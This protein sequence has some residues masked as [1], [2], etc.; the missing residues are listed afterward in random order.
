MKTNHNHQRKENQEMQSKVYV[1]IGQRWLNNE[2]TAYMPMAEAL[3]ALN[4]TLSELYSDIQIDCT[5]D[6]TCERSSYDI[7]AYKAFFKLVIKTKQCKKTELKR[8]I[9]AA[10]CGIDVLHNF[11]IKELM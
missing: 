4:T 10:F 11:E 1:T 8:F 6:N 3:K 2:K 5:Q 9:A 7:C